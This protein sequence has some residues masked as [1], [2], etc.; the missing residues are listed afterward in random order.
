LVWIANIYMSL[1]ALIKQEIKKEK[2][3][4]TVMEKETKI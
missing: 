2:T 3:E 4:I 1:F